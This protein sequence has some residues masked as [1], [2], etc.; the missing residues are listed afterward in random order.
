LGQ[1]GGLKGK[2]SPDRTD[3]NW[4]PKKTRPF[5]PNDFNPLIKRNRE[6]EPVVQVGI[7]VLRDVFIDG[8]V[9]KIA[10]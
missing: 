10:G 5:S 4:S 6:S 1:G 8:N 7:E 3:R 2:T 9:P